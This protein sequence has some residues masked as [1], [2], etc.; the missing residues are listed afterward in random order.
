MMKYPSMSVAASASATRPRRPCAA[1][2]SASRAAGWI[3]IGAMT[4]QSAPGAA[5]R[6][7]GQDAPEGSG[8]VPA[9]AY[10]VRSV[11]GPKTRSRRSHSYADASQRSCA[12]AP[13]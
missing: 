7:A 2:P 9:S 6:S 3:W 8:E 4:H 13:A 10:F 11:V 1:P 12:L 5:C